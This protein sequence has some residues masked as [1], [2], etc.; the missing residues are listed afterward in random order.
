MSPSCQLPANGG[1][2]RDMLMR[3]LCDSINKSPKLERAH[4][5]SRSLDRKKIPQVRFA[6]NRRHDNMNTLPSHKA[7]GAHDDFDLPIHTDRTSGG[8]GD[9]FMYDSVDSAV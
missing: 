1:P 3:E 2:H 8:S 7:Y 5:D 6:T 4:Y 9:Y